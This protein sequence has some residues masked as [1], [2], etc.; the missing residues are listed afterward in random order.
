[1]SMKVHP[2]GQGLSR[3]RSKFY[4]TMETEKRKGASKCRRTKQLRS[5][6]W[7]LFSTRRNARDPLSAAHRKKEDGMYLSRIA[8][9]RSICGMT[10]A[11]EG[12]QCVSGYVQC[13]VQHAC[14]FLKS[15]CATLTMHTSLH[16]W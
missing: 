3:S 9:E 5:E 11:R 16:W 1:M 7:V 15:Q 12:K 14:S 6:M 10:S 13:R 2:L 8:V 4:S